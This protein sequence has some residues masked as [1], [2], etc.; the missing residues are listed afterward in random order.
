MKNLFIQNAHT[1]LV[2]L[3]VPL[4][5]KDWRDTLYVSE[6]VFYIKGKEIL[7]DGV[8]IIKS[9]LQAYNYWLYNILKIE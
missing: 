8:H 3:K 2:E 9:E 5:Y 6:G 4:L 7:Q 1:L